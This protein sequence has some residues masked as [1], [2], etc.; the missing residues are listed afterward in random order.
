MSEYIKD[1]EMISK[2]YKKWATVAAI[3]TAV[4]GS[5]AAKKIYDLHKE[6]KTAKDNDYRK[7]VK[8][9]QKNH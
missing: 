6:N 1:A 5:V 3:G 4:V 8:K 9:R 7:Y 2:D